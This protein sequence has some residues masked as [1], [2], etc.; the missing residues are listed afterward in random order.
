MPISYATLHFPLH[1][2]VLLA[3]SPL[4]FSLDLLTRGKCLHCLHFFLFSP[5]SCMTYTSLPHSHSHHE[6]T[7]RLLAGK[8]SLLWLHSMGSAAPL[9]SFLLTLTSPSAFLPQGVFSL[10]LLSELTHGEKGDACS[11]LPAS[12]LPL[13]RP[14]ASRLC[15]GWLHWTCQI[16]Q[17]E[18]H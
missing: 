18:K 3:L 17:G 11:E 14:W 9:A 5:V 4:S 8:P 12:P 15:S 1:T 13:S 10:P 7:I 2:Q 6:V 16:S